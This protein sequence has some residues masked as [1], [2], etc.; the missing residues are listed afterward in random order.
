MDKNRAKNWAERSK[1][2]RGEPDGSPVLYLKINGWR[3]GRPK[4]V[5]QSAVQ[6]AHEQAGQQENRSDHFCATEKKTK[7]LITF[8]STQRARN[9][10]EELCEALEMIWY[11][12]FQAECVIDYCKKRT[13]FL[14]YS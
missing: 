4:G 7:E 1:V 6:I 12:K 5:I 11:K 14:K 9:G 10:I 2:A 13:P 3:L 8:V